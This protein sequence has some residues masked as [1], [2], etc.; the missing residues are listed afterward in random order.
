MLFGQLIVFANFTRLLER[1]L[2]GE[3]AAY[4]LPGIVGF[5]LLSLFRE[6]CP[7]SSRRRKSL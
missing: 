1:L 2:E 6:F 4:V 7:T 3:K 5:A